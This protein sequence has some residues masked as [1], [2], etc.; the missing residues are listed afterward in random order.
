[1]SSCEKL[2]EYW[3]KVGNFCGKSENTAKVIDEYIKYRR[4][5]RLEASGINRTAM[6]PLLQIEDR[7]YLHQ[8]CMKSLRSLL[9]KV[10]GKNITRRMVI[11]LINNVNNTVP[12][13]ER[14][15][16]IPGVRA[17][18]EGNQ[19]A[20]EGLSWETKEDFKRLKSLFGEKTN[21][22]SL[23]ILFEYV[24]DK[25]EDLLELERKMSPYFNRKQN[26]EF[27]VVSTT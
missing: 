1:M 13:N 8:K 16:H 11:E 9:K 14:I 20:I 22:V 17:K 23:R 15:T 19:H 26:T 7:T 3:Q 4:R 6:Y 2:Y 12:S 10:S 21:D 27:Q 24:K 25:N 5:H 18:M